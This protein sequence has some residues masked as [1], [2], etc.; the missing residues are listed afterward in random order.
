M[1][2]HIKIIRNIKK[3]IPLNVK[4]LIIRLL[5]MAQGFFY[6]YIKQHK[7]IS[8]SSSKRNIYILL[9]TD[10]SNLG[11]HAM[12]YA[13]I[14]MLKENFPDSNIIE[15]LVGDTIKN[16]KY[17]SKIIK[18]D[19]VITL[20]GGGNIGIEYFREELIRR[21][22]IKTFVNN[23]I[24]LFPQ[25]V[26]FPDTVIGRKEFDRTIQVFN[27][28]K[29][30]YKFFRDKVS[31]DLMKNK[32]NEKVFLTPDIVLSL[33]K[34]S[35]KDDTYRDG[36][37]TC[38]RSDVEGIYNNEKKE[39]LLEVLKQK[40][41]KVTVTDTIKEY[42]IE[43]SEREKELKD[44]WDLFSKSELIVT[45]RLHG[46]IFAALTSTPCIVFKTYNHKLVAQYDWLK[47]LDYLKNIEFE[48]EKIVNTIEYLS[49]LEIVSFDNSIYT[50]YFE[51][52]IKAIGSEYASG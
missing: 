24:I 52:I 2:N 18:K 11:D 38:L 19:D 8:A 20:K 50:E 7:D 6:G 44:I 26:Y 17:I 30:F 31:Y 41:K 25:T 37:V 23:K 29:Q 5:V 33:G 4:L 36:V 47:D 10:Y 27:S 35:S 34:I 1:W 42:Y 16:L 22:I 32:L 48:R 12:T 46:M 9:S 28:H 39:M 15:V 21:K 14:Q 45:D 3:L 51:Q 13:H 49:N 43:L 40:Y